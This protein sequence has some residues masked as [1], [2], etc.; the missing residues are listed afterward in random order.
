MKKLLEKTPL[1]SNKIGLFFNARVKKFNG[2]KPTGKH[3]FSSDH[4]S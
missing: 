3:R 1:K 2:I 4:R